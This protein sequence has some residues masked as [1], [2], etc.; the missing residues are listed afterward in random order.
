MSKYKVGDV[1]IAPISYMDTKTGL[2]TPQNRRWIVVKVEED[3]DEE[4]CQNVTV[5]CTGQLHQAERHPGITIKQ[6][7]KDGIDMQLTMD[8]FVYCD[9]TVVYLDSEIIRKKGHCSRINE[10]LNLLKL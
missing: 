6:N 10:I 9:R 2:Y 7:S 5:S 1:V 8:T 4:D 3:P